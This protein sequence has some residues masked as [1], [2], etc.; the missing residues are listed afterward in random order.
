VTDNPYTVRTPDWRKKD[1]LKR[2]Y[3]DYYWSTGQIADW[4][5]ETSNEISRQLDRNDIPARTQSE[6]ATVQHMKNRGESLEKIS[7]RVPD[8][9]LKR[10]V[11][12]TDSGT[13]VT[14]SD[15]E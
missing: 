15:I 1:Q 14:W 11:S 4:V 3:W 6:A 9:R 13:D 7:T 10:D 12:T 2:A 8:P 5:G